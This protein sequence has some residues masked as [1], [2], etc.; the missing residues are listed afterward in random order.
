MKTSENAVAAYALEFTE[1][2]GPL[3]YVFFFHGERV[4]EPVLCHEPTI[5]F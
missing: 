3:Y 4:V 5:I 2:N 1:Q